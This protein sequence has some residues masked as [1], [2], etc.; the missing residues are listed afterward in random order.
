M[1]AF[2]PPYRGITGILLDHGHRHEEGARAQRRDVTLPLRC[3][4]FV[5]LVRAERRPSSA[6]I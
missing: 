1:V 5:G 4:F 2:V 3:L 6:R